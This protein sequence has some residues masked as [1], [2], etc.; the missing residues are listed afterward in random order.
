[1]I[2]LNMWNDV[3]QRIP[4]GSSWGR[5]KELDVVS[6]SNV[7][8]CMSAEGHVSSLWS[9][10]SYQVLGVLMVHGVLFTLNQ[11]GSFKFLF[12]L[13]VTVNLSKVSYQAP[14]KVKS[15]FT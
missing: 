11:G 15:F 9:L 13:Q 12:H 8:T 14:H 2:V 1:M 4:N 7:G 6:V 3:S 10:T 5:A